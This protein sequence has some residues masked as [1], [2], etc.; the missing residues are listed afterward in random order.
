M[1]AVELEIPPRSVYVGVVRL[2]LASMARNAGI[3]EETIDHLKIA[4]SEACANAVLA[5]DE[6]KL[7]EPFG[8]SW[9]EDSHHVV[10]EVC[11]RASSYDIEPGSELD[12]HG[13]STRLT[14]S[15]ALMASL[16]DEC[17]F[18]KRD[19]GGTCARLVL[20]R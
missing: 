13:I 8:V 15:A 12:S 6:L 11:D 14:M 20:N 3:D 4:V 5:H 2:A 10:V 16:V 18:S 17:T 9:S 1:A 7:A 19:G